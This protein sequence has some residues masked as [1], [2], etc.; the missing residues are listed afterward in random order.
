[1]EAARV[2]VEHQR[3]KPSIAVPQRQIENAVHTHPLQRAFWIGLMRCTAVIGNQ[4]H[5]PQPV[6]ALLAETGPTD[7]TA[8]DEGS[9]FDP[10]LFADLAAHA[11][12]HVFIRFELAAQAVVLAQMLIVQ[13]RV[14]MDQ[15]HMTAIRR[16]HVTESSDDGGIRHAVLP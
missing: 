4:K 14:A 8:Q 15:Q 10:G 16:Q 12:D 1:M 9:A 11:R 13:T 5:E 3:Q 7:R 2:V 6:F